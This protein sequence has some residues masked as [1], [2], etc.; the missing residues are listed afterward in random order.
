MINPIIERSSIDVKSYHASVL[1]VSPA[2]LDAGS[3]PGGQQKPLS[4]RDDSDF[5]LW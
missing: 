4:K 1:K 5:N 3:V 2:A